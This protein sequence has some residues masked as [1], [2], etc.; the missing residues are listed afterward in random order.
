M[1]I[2][3]KMVEILCSR[4][5]GFLVTLLDIQKMCSI[6]VHYEQHVDRSLL[7]IETDCLTFGCSLFKKKVVHGKMLSLKKWQ[8]SLTKS[9]LCSWV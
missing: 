8:V 4:F 6:F 7:I 3:L 9:L 5:L 2:D 1:A